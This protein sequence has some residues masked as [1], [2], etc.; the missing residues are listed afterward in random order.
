VGDTRIQ[1]LV[2]YYTFGEDRLAKQ[3]IR[4][5][6][7]SRQAEGFTASRYPTNDFQIITTFSLLWIGMVHDFWKYRDDQNF[8]K[9]MLAGTRTVLDFFNGYAQSDGTIKEVPWWNFMDWT[10]TFPRGVPKRGADGRSAHMDLLHLHALQ[11]AAEMEENLG[12]PNLAKSLKNRIEILKASI[13]KLYWDP[14]TG[15]YSDVTSFDQFSQHV[16]SLAVITGVCP[17]E[18]QKLLMEKTLTAKD[19][20]PCTIYFKYYLH[21]A[22][23]KAGL[24]DLYLS[25]LQEWK[26]QLAIGLST[27]AESPEPSRSDCHAWGCS[28]NIEFYRIVLGI[29]SDT[30]GFASVKITPHLGT[31]KIAEGKIPHPKGL[32]EVKYAITK[33]GMTAKI[34]LPDGISGKL[35][36]K[37]KE[38]G[39]TGSK[40]IVDLN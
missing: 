25:W 15:F 30:P 24:G 28:P 34:S 23:T 12:D 36:W 19:M 6:Y 32:I 10:A 40:Q 33:K 5:I 22:A 21:Q 38:F 37:G 27:W 9:E 3:A 1:A 35:I 26:N 8:V 20:A 4:A 17:A 7:N 18:M 13:Q 29:D 39:L 14:K 16:N 11:L 31:L 2:S